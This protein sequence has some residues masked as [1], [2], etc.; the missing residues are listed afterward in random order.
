M[1]RGL[2]PQEGTSSVLFL[3]LENVF[4]CFFFLNKCVFV[5]KNI[6][7]LRN[8]YKGKEIKFLC[9]TKLPRHLANG[10]K[11]E[12]REMEKLNKKENQKKEKN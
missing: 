2:S 9:P 6:L 7:D 3:L 8:C 5:W 4:F 1:G 12:S 10:R 11:R